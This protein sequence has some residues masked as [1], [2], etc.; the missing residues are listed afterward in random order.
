MARNEI[1]AAAAAA[2]DRSNFS[3]VHLFILLFRRR[4]LITRERH[5]S[6][7]KMICEWADGQPSSNDAT[8]DHFT[9]EFQLV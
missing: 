2:S 4:R 8:I 9:F 7:K 6:S 3:Q 5:E 1:D